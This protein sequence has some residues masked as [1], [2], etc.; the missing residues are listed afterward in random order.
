MELKGQRDSTDMCGG[1]VPDIQVNPNFLF[2]N[3]FLTGL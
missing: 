3:S 1:F 2:Y